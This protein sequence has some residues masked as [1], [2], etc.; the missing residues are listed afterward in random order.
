M[1]RKKGFS[2]FEV[3]LVLTILLLIASFAV[4][5]V[6]KKIGEAKDTAAIATLRGL[7]S[8]YRITYSVL[9]VENHAEGR[10]VV[11][12]TVHIPCREGD[13]PSAYT[14]F[15]T[16]QMNDSYAGSPPCYEITE[17]TDDTGT[18]YEI[19]YWPDLERNPLLCYVLRDNG[20]YRTERAHPAEA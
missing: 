9:V 13:A 8:A 16:Q 18:A 3:L 19:A 5:A 2:T 15:V 4:P 1:R 20:I 11:A 12:G 7:E 17:T 14:D 6:W 10:G